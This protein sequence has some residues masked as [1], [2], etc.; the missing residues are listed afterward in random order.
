MR[1]WFLFYIRLYK[2]FNMLS[3][4][5]VK[6]GKRKNFDKD[7]PNRANV[8]N[9]PFPGLRPFRYEESHLFFGREGQ[10]DE[11]VRKLM[12]HRF[13]GVIGTSGI[14]KSSFMYCGLLPIL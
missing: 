2:L 12:L 9:N 4:K 13:V 3:T 11:V 7:L 6:I 10:I 8:K 1:I 5:S 14:G